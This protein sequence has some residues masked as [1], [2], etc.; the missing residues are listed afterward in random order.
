MGLV[1]WSAGVAVG[2]TVPTGPLPNDV[3]A[4][5]RDE[6]FGLVAS[7]RGLPLGVREKLESL[8]SS[9]SLDIAEPTAPFQSAGAKPGS[10]LP[11]RRLVAAGCSNSRCLVYYE[12]GGTPSTWRVMFFHWTPDETTLE[13]GATAP[14]GLKTF[15][16]VRAAVLKGAGLGRTTDW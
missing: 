3:R 14:G 10:N 2:Q 16:D 5:I 13:W 1:L 6:R 4:R 12:R 9:R 11:A 7:L 15:E 8:F